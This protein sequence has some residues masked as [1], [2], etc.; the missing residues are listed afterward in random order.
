MGHIYCILIIVFIFITGTLANNST[1]SSCSTSLGCNLSIK[2]SAT[3]AWKP[4][5]FCSS[6]VKSTS[7]VNS[8]PNPSMNSPVGLIVGVTFGA[9]AILA[10]GGFFSWKLKKKFPNKKPRN[11]DEEEM[12]NIPPDVSLPQVKPSPQVSTPLQAPPSQVA[13]LQVSPAPQVST[14]LQ[15]PPSQVATLQVSP[16]L[17]VSPPPEVSLP[18]VK[19]APQVSTPLQA[20]QVS[21]PL[22]PPS[23]TPEDLDKLG[24]VNDNVRRGTQ[25]NKNFTYKAKN[26][27][28]FF[29]SY[30]KKSEKILAIRL[31]DLLN[32]R[33]YDSNRNYPKISC[34]FDEYSLKGGEKYINELDD[35]I[36]NT[37]III[38]LLSEAAI[39]DYTIITKEKKDNLLHEWEIALDRKRAGQGAIYPI[40]VDI[41][42]G[43]HVYK[44]HTFGIEDYP[45]VNAENT[46]K[47]VRAIMT[48]LM[49][50]QAYLNVTEKSYLDVDKLINKLKEFEGQ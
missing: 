8:K 37:S 47:S 5:N 46:T 48:E 26:R 25:V 12:K 15:A 9:A 7:M 40:L 50:Y 14:P 30:R 42:E 35:S 33:E 22:S 45:N 49:Q 11:T 41:E 29:I 36:N 24:M 28:D 19:P 34:F 31:F 13:A 20:L 39:A 38:I 43:A 32:K 2:G 21:T 18:Q 23:L 17:Q 3:Y 16:A 10:A 6:T 4:F 27:Y 1:S 44:F